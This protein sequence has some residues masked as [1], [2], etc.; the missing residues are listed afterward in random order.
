MGCTKQL[1][2]HT[3]PLFFIQ[4]ANNSVG[5][6]IRLNYHVN[7]FPSFAC[8]GLLQQGAVLA[9]RHGALARSVVLLDGGEL[10]SLEYSKTVQMTALL[11]FM[12][13]LLRLLKFMSHSQ[14]ELLSSLRTAVAT[15]R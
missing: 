9:G 15:I 8:D 10:P 2:A 3:W 7:Y 12:T 13:L 1:P 11:R 6:P 5:L 14:P 4:F